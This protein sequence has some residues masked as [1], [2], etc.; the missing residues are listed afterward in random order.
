MKS[1]SSRNQHTTTGSDL[2]PKHPAM[3]MTFLKLAMLVK[4]G[5][6]HTGDWQFVRPDYN[7]PTP[8]M[9]E[10][11]RQKIK[12]AEK[13][14]PEVRNTRRQCPDCG[15]Y[16]SIKSSCCPSGRMWVCLECAWTETFKGE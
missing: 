3:E 12:E 7:K 16:L 1:Q 10:A 14:V 8:E 13:H 11:I 15:Y 9:D 4:E 6:A 5:K 2:H